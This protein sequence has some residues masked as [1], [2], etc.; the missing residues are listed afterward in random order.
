MPEVQTLST[1]W[2][3]ETGLVKIEQW[4]EGYVVWFG[5]EIVFKSWAKKEAT[6]KIELDVS[7]IID[8][9]P[10]LSKEIDRLKQ[11]APTSRR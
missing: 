6:L 2:S 3:D 10:Y 5:G 9:I 8:E 11:N 7:K 1:Y 4:P